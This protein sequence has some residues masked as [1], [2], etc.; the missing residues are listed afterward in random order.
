M[1]RIH[2][3]CCWVGGGNDHTYWPAA[4]RNTVFRRR[5]ITYLSCARDAEF[6]RGPRARPLF[7]A[8]TRIGLMFTGD[9]DVG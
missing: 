5:P 3:A 9:Q 6:L 4:C 1:A 7:P 8:M 2:P